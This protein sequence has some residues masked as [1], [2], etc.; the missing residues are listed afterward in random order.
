MSMKKSKPIF[1]FVSLLLVNTAK[2]SGQS[3]VLLLKDA[4]AQALAHN[5][6]LKASGLARDIAVNNADP[7]LAGLYPRV[8]VSANGGAV[9]SDTRLEFAQAGQPPVEVSG[10]Q[11]I[12]YGAGVT[13][14]YRLFD[15]LGNVYTLRQL[16]AQADVSET[17]FRIAVENTM[18]ATIVEFFNLARLQEQ[19][20]IDEENL[21]I[22]S[23]RYERAKRKSEMGSGSS[24]E[25]S[26]A[27]V[28]LRNDSLQLIR[29]RTERDNAR[30]SLNTLLGQE[31]DAPFTVDAE[32]Q[33][34]ALPNDSS[35]YAMLEEQNAAVLRSREA[36]KAQAYAQRVARS[37]FIPRLDLN[38][39]YSYSAQENE[40]GLLLF[41]RNDGVNAGLTLQWDLFNG[42]RNWIQGENA[43]LAL[44]QAKETRSQQLLAAKQELRSALAVYRQALYS[45]QIARRNRQS[46]ELNFTRAKE[47]FALGQI[48]NTQ[49]REAQLNLQNS[50]N[51]RNN[52]LFT[53]KVAE[54]EVLRLCGMLVGER[55]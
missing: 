15:G 14:T 55:P 5:H 34:E 31:G 12:S 41:Q 3:E 8:V 11:S 16:Q 1:F 45:V 9:N 10:A 53:A 22:S 24:F 2:L 6:Q 35:L 25:L 4:I 37:A 33:F 23:S 47:L 39:G 20:R 30:R 27:E 52:A 29:T 21:G 7:G 54:T 43:R 13:L 28:D 42:K 48:D 32:V 51:G 17:E 36:V 18:T 46:A 49:F 26:S 50:I 40:V 38:A 44:A 19:T